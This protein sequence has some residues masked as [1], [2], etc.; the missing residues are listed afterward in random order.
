MIKKKNKKAFK[1]KTQTLVTVHRVLMLEHAL[2]QAQAQP[3]IAH[4]QLATQAPPVRHVG[5]KLLL[6]I[7]TNNIF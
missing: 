6:K 2:L 3:S 1:F 5:E 4:V 7:E